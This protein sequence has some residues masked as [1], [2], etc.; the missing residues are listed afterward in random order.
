MGVSYSDHQTSI[1]CPRCSAIPCRCSALT[2]A[3]EAFESALHRCIAHRHEARQLLL[4]AT[5]KSTDDTP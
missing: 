4:G 3:L 1:V 5:K 2:R